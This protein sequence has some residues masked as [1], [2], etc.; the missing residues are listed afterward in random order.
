VS[1]FSTQL[2]VGSPQPFF[3]VSAGWT[4]VPSILH[5]RERDNGGKPPAKEQVPL[6]CKEQLKQGRLD[7][8]R[9]LGEREKRQRSKSRP[10][11]ASPG[12]LLLEAL[13]ICLHPLSSLLH[14]NALSLRER[15]IFL[16]V[17]VIVLLSRGI[18]I[19]LFASGS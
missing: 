1:F 2:V 10:G 11:E 14:N 12:L 17:C 18:F 3:F 5:T 9:V 7:H 13:M 4:A 6:Q 15:S 16:F 8:R 19:S